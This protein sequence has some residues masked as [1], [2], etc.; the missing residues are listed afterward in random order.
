[1]DMYI[2]PFPNPFLCC[3]IMFFYMYRFHNKGV[4]T[5]FFYI[6]LLLRG[7]CS[8][9]LIMV[10]KT[11]IFVMLILLHTS[12][13]LHLLSSQQRAFIFYTLI[14]FKGFVG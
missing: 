13:H 4:Y 9:S 14:I 1:M 2:F 7:F 5:W 6:C 3:I 12:L 8:F 11:V 10:L